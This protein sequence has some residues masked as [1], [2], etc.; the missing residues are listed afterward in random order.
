MN[1]EIWSTPPTQV[2]EIGMTALRKILGQ[3]SMG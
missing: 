2:G 3:S 1:P